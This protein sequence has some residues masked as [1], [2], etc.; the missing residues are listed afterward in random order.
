MKEPFQKGLV[1]NA[2]GAGYRMGF[3]ASSDHYSTHISYAN[4][5][6]PARTTTRDDLLDAFD[7]AWREYEEAL[8]LWDLFADDRPAQLDH[9][10]L[11]H[12]TAYA[13]YLSGRYRR[14]VGACREAIEELA[15]GDAA[16]SCELLALLDIEPLADQVVINLPYG[17]QRRLEIARALATKPKVLLLDEPGN[18]LDE[19]GDHALSRA[20]QARRGETTVIIG[21]P[22]RIPRSRRKGR[23]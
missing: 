5:I 10:E 6:V 21:T 14:A 7:I 16:R 1:W 17:A 20:I 15:D 13:A 11:L 19:E 8:S 12:R 3:T 9:V 22:W 23:S 2:L 18:G 4:L